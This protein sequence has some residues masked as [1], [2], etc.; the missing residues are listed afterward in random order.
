MLV[1][2]LDDRVRE[3]RALLWGVDLCGDSGERVPSPVGIV[4]GDRFAESLQVGAD[5][6]GQRDV[7]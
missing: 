3:R 4:V 7:Q 5:Q 1:A 6:F 2:E